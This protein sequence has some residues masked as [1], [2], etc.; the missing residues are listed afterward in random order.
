DNLILNSIQCNPTIE[1][2]II[3][4]SYTIQ[5]DTIIFDYRDNGIGLTG[6]YKEDPLLTLEVHESSREEGHGLG[7]W[8]INNSLHYI[9][10]RVTKIYN[11]NGYRINFVLKG[12]EIG[13]ETD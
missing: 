11:D 8:I 4:I 12:V 1:K 5:R 7:M 10:G 9:D 3:N 13:D 2:L 6:I